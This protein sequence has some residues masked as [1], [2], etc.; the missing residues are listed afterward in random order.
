MVQVFDNSIHKLKLQFGLRAKEPLPHFLV[1]GTQKGGT[2]SLHKLLSQHPDVFLPECKEVQYFSL[3]ADK[4]ISWYGE[5]FNSA[6]P[7]Q[8]RGK[9]KKQNGMKLTRLP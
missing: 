9:S 8:R 7:G 3:H 5:Q 6:K 4:P 1:I 2:T